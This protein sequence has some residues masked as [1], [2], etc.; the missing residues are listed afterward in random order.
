[1]A[2]KAQSRTKISQ[3]FPSLSTA[4]NLLLHRVAQQNEIVMMVIWRST[5]NS[6][7]WGTE[8]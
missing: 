1:V 2:T 4:I 3:S 8:M 6:P 5:V 7:Q